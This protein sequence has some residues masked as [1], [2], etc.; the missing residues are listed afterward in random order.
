MKNVVPFKQ[1]EIVQQHGIDWTRAPS[2]KAERALREAYLTYE[3]SCGPEGLVSV[4]L[5]ATVTRRQGAVSQDL[6]DAA[7][8]A[9]ILLAMKLGKHRS[10]ALSIANASVTDTGPLWKH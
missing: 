4:L 9:E 5:L 3:T 2:T 7:D 10:D 6:Q 8:F 1:P